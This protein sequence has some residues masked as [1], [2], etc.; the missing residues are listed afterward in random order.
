MKEL[1]E[2]KKEG[3]RLI[4]KGRGSEIYR[5]LFSKF[6]TATEVSEIIYPNIYSKFV[7]L[8]KGIKSSKKPYK[9]RRPHN[10]VRKYI[11]VFQALNWLEFKED[12]DK[13]K[14]FYRSKFENY[15]LY[16]L[17]GKVLNKIQKEFI[18]Q[19][20]EEIRK[21]IVKFDSDFFSSID[22]II[23]EKIYRYFTRIFD[24]LEKINLKEDE[25]FPIYISLANIYLDKFT[26]KLMRDYIFQKLEHAK[27]KKNKNLKFYEALYW[28]FHHDEGLGRVIIKFPKGFIKKIKGKR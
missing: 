9:K 8:K 4:V 19:F 16:S 10:V 11:E 25:E 23:K 28:M 3:E 13:R 17:N 7:K 1:E 24:N 14:K 18:Y 20:E 5:I 26:L 2:L 12:K 22:N 21:E 27:D 15:F 6:I